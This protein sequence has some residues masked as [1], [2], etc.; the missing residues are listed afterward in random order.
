MFKHTAYV[1]HTTVTIIFLENAPDRTDRE[2]KI[3]CSDSPTLLA[4][5]VPSQAYLAHHQP[6]S[7]ARHQARM[8]AEV[9]YMESARQSLFAA[10][11][12][13]GGW[14]RAYPH[15]NGPAQVSVSRFSFLVFLF[16]F[17]FYFMIF[18]FYLCFF[19]CFSF[20]DIGI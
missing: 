3:R 20:F 17:L 8:H 6:N 12:G 9:A 18:H 10:F 4:S 1:S 19:F 2:E 16:P 5:A 11:S 15:H 7:P 14:R 13:A